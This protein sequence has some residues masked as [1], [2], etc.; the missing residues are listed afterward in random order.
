MNLLYPTTKPTSV[1][2]ELVFIK[3]EVEATLNECQEQVQQCED[4]RREQAFS[5][6]ANKE[7]LEGLVLNWAYKYIMTLYR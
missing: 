2:K 6:V 7:F 4:S 5:T 3:A 1:R